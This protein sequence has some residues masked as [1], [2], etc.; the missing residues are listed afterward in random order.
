LQLA[1]FFTTVAKTLKYGFFRNFIIFVIM[2]YQFWLYLII[3]VIYFLSRVLKKKEPEPGK[4]VVQNK[5]ESYR[6][7][8]NQ[9]SERPK[10]LTFE[11]LLKEITEAKQPQKQVVLPPP[12]AQREYVDYDDD[13][14]EEEQD[15]ETID[16]DYRKKDKVYDVY[17][18]AK[19][20]AFVRP[21]LEETLNIRDTD[22]R[23]GKFKVFDKAKQRNLLEDYTLDLKDP[24][25]LKK[26]FVLSEILN[27]KF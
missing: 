25:G 17:E 12:Q 18:D 2:D 13:I 23:F 10:A 1:V 24:E 26:A 3:G 8:Q 6:Q 16:T 22:M 14:A 7:A 20:Q 5:P 4:E 19:R 27:R 9:Q 11:E 15:L 21:S